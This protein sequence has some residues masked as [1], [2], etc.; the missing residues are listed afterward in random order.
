MIK[1]SKIVVLLADHTKFGR[2]ALISF[3]EL[4]DIHVLITDS[5]TDAGVLDS[6]AQMGVRIVRTT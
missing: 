2:T 3:A 6:I 4:K 1:S 5:Y